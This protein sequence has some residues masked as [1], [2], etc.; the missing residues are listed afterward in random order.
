MI[1]LTYA[2]DADK[3]TLALIAD[4]D[5]QQEIAEMIDYKGAN[6]ATE[7]DALEYLLGNSELQW[8][9]PSDTGDLTDAPIL[10]ILGE[11]TTDGD[12]P[13]PY[14]LCYISTDGDGSIF[15]PI[16]ERWAFMDYAVRSFLTDL[17]TEGQAVFTNH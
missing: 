13:G 10:G 15:A 7:A 3:G 14:G 9:D 5:A 11:E 6:T 12:T 4:A 16:I 17:A 8:I 2:I 1:Q